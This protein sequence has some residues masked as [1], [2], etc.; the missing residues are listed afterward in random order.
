MMK[1]I[2]YCIKRGD[3]MT[4]ENK[5][6][7]K[8]LDELAEDAFHQTEFDNDNMYITIK[9]YD[10]DVAYLDVNGEEFDI[11]MWNIFDINTDKF[12]IIYSLFKIDGD[13]EI[14]IKDDHLFIK[15]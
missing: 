12:E 13:N 5:T 1:E 3:F 2:F 9:D 15:K 10:L 6:D 4:I 14:C 7:N 8:Y 11:R